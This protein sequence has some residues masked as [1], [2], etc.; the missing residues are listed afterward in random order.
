MRTQ[1]IAEVT[2]RSLLQT[3]SKFKHTVILQDIQQY[4]SLCRSACLMDY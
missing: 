1:Q 4:C 2:K 3:H